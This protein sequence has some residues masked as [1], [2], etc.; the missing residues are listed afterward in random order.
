MEE[1]VE[2]SKNNNE[3]AFSKLISLNQ[4]DLYYIAR[5]RLKYENDINDAIQQ[6]VLLAYQNIKKLKEP[7]YFKIWITKILVNECNKIYN[8][9]KRKIIIFENL[10]NKSNRTEEDKD[11]D[12][13]D[14]KMDLEKRI[15]NLEYDEKI[16][17]ILYYK[18]GYSIKEMS[19]ILEQKESS[20]KSKMS[21][22]RA[23]IKY[24]QNIIIKK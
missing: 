24:N 19:D 10:I 13:I 17:I 6:A 4:S 7:K 16:C 1:L 2:K 15:E 5:A 8:Q 11:Y 3:D 21:R 18:N 20:I 22:T 14:V 9:K 12:N 23:K